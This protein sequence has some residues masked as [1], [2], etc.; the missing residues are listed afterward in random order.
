MP[1]VSTY[2][3]K[4]PVKI[5]KDWG[6]EL[7]FADHPEYAGKLLVFSKAGNNFSYH[8]H[9]GKK[10]TWFVQ[11]GWF[12][13]IISS[14]IKDEDY[15]RTIVLKQGTCITI[16]PGMVHQLIAME[17]NSWV[18]EVSTQDDEMDNHRITRKNLSE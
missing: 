16:E 18:I 1:L 4:A 5:V 10:E 9:M 12:K 6:Y 8:F 3:S 13:L 14:H 17:D 7:I 11:N 2:S 15:R